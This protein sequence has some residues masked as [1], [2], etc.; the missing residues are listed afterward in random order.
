VA[1][2]NR[3]GDLC[4]KLKAVINNFYKNSDDVDWESDAGKLQLEDDIKKMLVCKPFQID[5]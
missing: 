1:Y 5:I 4:R 3:R 2:R